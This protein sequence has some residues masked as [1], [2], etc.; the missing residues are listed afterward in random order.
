MDA[1]SQ[2][3][4]VDLLRP[5]SVWKLQGFNC[6]G[7]ICNS[8]EQL[9]HFVL[10]KSGSSPTDQL[11][12]GSLFLMTAAPR[13]ATLAPQWCDLASVLVAVQRSER[14]NC[15]RKNLHIHPWHSPDFLCVARQVETSLTSKDFRANPLIG[16][17]LRTNSWSS[18]DMSARSAGSQLKYPTCGPAP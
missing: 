11:A 12:L 14:W 3:M 5:I 10:G 2:C 1:P 4:K 15:Q 17:V 18:P 9:A 8:R 16:M 7:S 13:D 6:L